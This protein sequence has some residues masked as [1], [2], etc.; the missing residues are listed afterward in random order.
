MLLE[1]GFGMWELEL[2]RESWLVTVEAGE[3][4]KQDTRDLSLKKEEAAV[5]VEVGGDGT[6]CSLPVY[7]FDQLVYCCVFPLP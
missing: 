6:A 5:E 7:A 1:L 4:S 2:G 3:E